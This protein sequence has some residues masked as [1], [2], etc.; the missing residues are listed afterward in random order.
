MKRP[1][2]LERFYRKGAETAPLDRS[3]FT[4]PLDRSSA[5]EQEGMEIDDRQ[6]IVSLTKALRRLL[7]DPGKYPLSDVQDNANAYIANMAESW[8]AI[9]SELIKEGTINTELEEQ[10]DPE[11]LG[12][13][14]ENMMTQLLGQDK[15]QSIRWQA[16]DPDSIRT[17][18]TIL[19]SYT[20]LDSQGPERVNRFIAKLYNEHKR[21]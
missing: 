12:K 20:L 11:K 15:R 16:G 18:D 2:D 6:N 13:L 8:G 9:R 3:R 4:T 21:F 10:T 14:F 1:G 5:T 17:M 7:K 19:I